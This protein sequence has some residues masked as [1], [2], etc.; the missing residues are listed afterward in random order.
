M[1]GT[2]S[3]ALQQK[4]LNM[5]YNILLNK[6]AEYS[7]INTVFTSREPNSFVLRTLNRNNI[8]GGNANEGRKN[9]RLS[10]GGYIQW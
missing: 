5:L 4:R 10:Q 1:D 6:G 3:M 8:V 2:S 9:N 7:K